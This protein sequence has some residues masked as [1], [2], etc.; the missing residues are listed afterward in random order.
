MFSITQSKSRV[1]KSKFGKLKAQLIDVPEQ[2]FKK[3]KKGKSMD[4]KNKFESIK[5]FMSNPFHYVSDKLINNRLIAKN[6]YVKATLKTLRGYESRDML[7]ILN[8]SIGLLP[9]SI[10][11]VSQAKNIIPK[12][13]SAYTLASRIAS[14]LEEFEKDEVEIDEVEEFLLAKEEEIQ[15][16]LSPEPECAFTCQEIDE[17]FTFP[18]PIMDWFLQNGQFGENIK[19]LHIW[20]A[21]T[22][23]SI[24]INELGKRT[25]ILLVEC[26]WNIDRLNSS[27]YANYF[28]GNVQCPRFYI[29]LRPQISWKSTSYGFE[30]A[31]ADTK[32][33]PYQFWNLDGEYINT[34]W[35][36]GVMIL[37]RMEY[38]KTLDLNN[39]IVRITRFGNF[40]LQPRAKNVT[41]V[42]DNIAEWGGTQNFVDKV[43]KALKTGKRY[44]A[45]LVGN[46]GTGKTSVINHI[47]AQI[48][49][50][51]IVYVSPDDINYLASTIEQLLPCVAVFEDIESFEIQHKSNRNTQ[52]MLSIL[53][54]SRF[55]SLVCIASV[56]NTALL[57][58]AIVR[59]G[60]FDD[61]IEV[62]EPRTRKAMYQ[63]IKHYIESDE[64]YDAASINKLLPWS[65]Y[66]KLRYVSKVTCSDLVGMVDSSKL[67]NGSVTAK[68]LKNAYKSFV[69]SRRV[70]EQYAM[71]DEGPDLHKRKKFLGLF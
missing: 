11:G 54:G 28:Q 49:D 61:I 10:P 40:E 17:H 52:T 6:K 53:D 69:L 63:I 48:G 70:V 38:L 20:N 31:S 24:G 35:I 22:H 68:S 56:N 57:T 34:A 16:H 44:G 23:K 4:L 62:H 13:A 26:Y 5:P 45:M 12:L 55:P 29:E 30:D 15:M 37:M 2:P 60:R 46:P 50:Y 19:I 42:Y 51:P 21:K 14:N 32:Y 27:E 41:F 59:T 7:N 1:S 65:L 58:P 67:Q 36:S 3:T 47:Q 39:N 9:S 8:E 64:G 25:D 33:N 71:A 18:K 66:F 43:N